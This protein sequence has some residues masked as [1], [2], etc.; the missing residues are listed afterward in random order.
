[1]AV[2]SVSPVGLGLLTMAHL[3]PFQCKI[4]DS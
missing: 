1:M 3:V 4:R 2:R